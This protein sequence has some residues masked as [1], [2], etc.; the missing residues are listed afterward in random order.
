MED[1]AWS[2]VEDAAW[3]GVEDAAWSGVEDAAWNEMEDTAWSEVEGPTRSVRG[4]GSGAL[5]QRRRATAGVMAPAATG[6]GAARLAVGPESTQPVTDR[7][8]A[9]SAFR[10]MRGP[11]RPRS[12]LRRF[13]LS[14]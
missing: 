9:A 5:P 1:A 14:S 10:S 12:S 6:A 13:H 4:P 7:R 11:Q 8:R 2:G 3:S